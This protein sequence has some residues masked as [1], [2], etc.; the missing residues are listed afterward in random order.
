MFLNYLS[1]STISTRSKRVLDKELLLS[2]VP[3][4]ITKL[5][6]TKSDFLPIEYQ[7][8]ISRPEG[9]ISRGLF[10]MFVDILFMYPQCL[11]SGVWNFVRRII[12][13]VEPERGLAIRCN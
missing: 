11:R 2:N 6:L 13:G 5:A 3:C 7:Y 10:K 4:P 9:R 8:L 12:C 1:F